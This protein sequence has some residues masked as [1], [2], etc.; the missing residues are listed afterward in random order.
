[1][2]RSIRTRVPRKKLSVFAAV[3]AASNDAASD[4]AA[5]ALVT[6]KPR[7]RPKKTKKKQNQEDRDNR[8]EAAL[9]ESATITDS[10]LPGSPI[11]LSILPLLSPASVA[12]V[13]SSLRSSNKNK[14]RKVA[15]DSDKKY[16]KHLALYGR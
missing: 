7:G 11:C 13:T 12:S 2:G 14:K 16:T 10:P 4:A 8:R 3:A 9:L 5:S 1:M 6:P 15:G